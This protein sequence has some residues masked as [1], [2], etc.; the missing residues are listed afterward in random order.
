MS[1]NDFQSALSASL[2]ATVNEFYIDWQYFQDL[3]LGAILLH[4]L[5]RQ[6]EQLYR[7]VMA[8]IPEYNRRV[9][10]GH[11]E[12]FPEV[13]LTDEYLEQFIADPVNTE[14]L[15]RTS[16]YTDVHH[17][18]SGFVGKIAEH[19]ER[20]GASSTQSQLVYYVN[21]FPLTL[22]PS[23]QQLVKSRIRYFDE[24]AKVGLIHKPIT[25]LNPDTYKKFRIAFIYDFIEFVREGTASHT[26]FFTYQFLK[27]FVLTPK[28][29]EHPGDI[30][31]EAR[32]K[33]FEDTA[34][35][36]N[37]LCE[38]SYFNSHIMHTAATAS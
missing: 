10:R 29:L 31:E 30:P 1:Q 27:S 23:L 35:A 18:F 33:V 6:D 19:I 12:Y 36:M 37:A 9:S 14:I 21:M 11:A 34:A 25:D 2:F 13:E 28:R 8:R 32:P 5:R 3:R 22:T 20:F 16:P 24:N 26:A 7:A 17:N 15:L 4:V 38:F